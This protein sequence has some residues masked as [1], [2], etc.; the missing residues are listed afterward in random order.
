MLK[1]VMRACA[2][3]AY[4]CVCVCASA[5]TADVNLNGVVGNKALLAI[6]GGK[7]R[8]VAVGETVPPGVKLISISG[9]TAVIE[10]GGKRESM[11]LGQSARLAGNARSSGS[12]SV[13]LTADNRGH[14]ITTGSIN[15]VSVRFLV[16]TGASLV[17]MSSSEAKRLGINYT[18]G[19][20]TFSSTANGVVPTYLVKLDEVRVGGVAVNNVDGMVH[21]GDSLPIVLL[22]MSFLNRMEMKRNGEQMMLMKRF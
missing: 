10:L 21:V 12:Q 5:A 14:F 16:D 4:L 1:I 7:P 18:A 15:G 3:I 13:T 8:W 20:K 6:D 19:Q 11:T 9:E 22:G 17:S 2:A